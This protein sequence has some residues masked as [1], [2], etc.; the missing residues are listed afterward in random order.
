[1]RF[2]VRIILLS[3]SDLIPFW[4]LN[5]FVLS[6]LLDVS[7]S[8]VDTL[9]ISLAKIKR[10]GKRRRRGQERKNKKQ[11]A[12]AWQKTRKEYTNLHQTSCELLKLQRHKRNFGLYEDCMSYRNAHGFRSGQACFSLFQLLSL[13]I[14]L[15]L[16]NAWFLCFAVF[17]IFSFWGW[18]YTFSGDSLWCSSCSF[19]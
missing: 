8:W 17:R 18:C 11:R 4:W 1:M 6:A 2:Q 15:F 7:R 14:V 13:S 19:H 16:Y 3:F 5:G 10:E 12:N 9:F